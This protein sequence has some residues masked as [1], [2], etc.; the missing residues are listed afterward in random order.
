MKATIAFNIDTDSLQG[1]N[2]DHLAQLWHIGQANP[3]PIQD[4]AAGELAEKIGR[5]IIR[6]WLGGVPPALWSH[7]GHHADWCVLHKVGANPGTEV[8]DNF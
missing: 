3:A 2:D 8:V 5:E 7:Q 4:R 6:R 1:Y